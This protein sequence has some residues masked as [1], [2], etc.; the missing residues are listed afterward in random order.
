MTAYLFPVNSEYPSA[1]L[2]GT[3]T[4]ESVNGWFNFTDLGVTHAGEYE[5]QFM[6]DEPEGASH[7]RYTLTACLH[8]VMMLLFASLLVE[9]SC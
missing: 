3:V 1:E 2:L 5:I 4:V 6:V 8:D 7:L 9:P